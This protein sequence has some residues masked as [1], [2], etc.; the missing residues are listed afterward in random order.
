MKA[1]SSI[2]VLAALLLPA[3]AFGQDASASIS[4]DVS[5]SGP[6]TSSLASSVSSEVSSET[7]SA[8]SE[9]SSAS[10]SMSSELSSA[11]SS[12]SSESSMSSEPVSSESSSESDQ[13]QATPA[14]VSIEVFFQNLA[15]HGVW[16]KDIRYHYVFCPKVDT[17]WRPYTNGHWVYLKDYGWYFASDEPFAW[18]VYHYGRWFD[19]DRLGWC[20]V[21]GNAWAGAW[22][23]W[24][25]GDEYVGWAPLGPAKDGFV[26]DVDAEAAEPPKDRWVFVPA[27]QFLD[28]ELNVTVVFGADEPDLFEVTTYVGPV[29]VENN[30]VVNNIINVTFIEQVTNQKVVMVNP[31][32]V[33]RPE[34]VS[35]NV[36]AGVIAIFSPQMDPPKQDEAPQQAVEVDQAVQDLGRTES[37]PSSEPSPALSEPSSEASSIQSE[38]SSEA[39]SAETSSSAESPSSSAASSAVSSSEPSSAPAS[40]QVPSSEVSSEP[41]VSSAPAS[42]EP[43]SSVPSLVEPSSVTSPESSE[44]QEPSAPSSEP[45]PEGYELIKGVCLPLESSAAQ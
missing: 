39:S 29:V 13:G 34:Q 4:G 40:E 22:V 24:R 36:E 7:S 33:D 21:P 25:Q 35:V 38:P 37:E 20:W 30:I 31:Q 14:T 9:V 5:V 45:C 17:D 15:P 32:V 3:A 23:S 19:D 2:A 16:V 43:S 8:A 11:A 41:A 10:S 1:L 42:E 26:I 28:L 6:D 27:K 44:P 12:A 18:A